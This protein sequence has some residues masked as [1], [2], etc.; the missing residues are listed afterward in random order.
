FANYPNPFNPET[1]ISFQL[2]KECQVR[3]S[4]YNNLGQLIS[5]L[6][7]GELGSGIHSKIWN[8]LDMSGKQ[9][10][11]GVYLYKL[12]TDEYSEVKKMLYIQ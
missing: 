7:E 8:G 5:V 1:K 11:S 6:F 2:P 9:V 4:V 10:T 12:E 3:L